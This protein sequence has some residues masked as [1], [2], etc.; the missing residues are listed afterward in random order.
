MAN[1]ATFAGY[2][3]ST[4][5]NW[6]GVY[7]ADGYSICLDSTSNPSYVTPAITGSTVP[8]AN[9]S[10]DVRALTKAS[11]PSQRINSSWYGSSVI[12]D[13]NIS[14]GT[15]RVGVYFFDGDNS[16]RTEQVQVLDG[17]TSAVLDTRALT[18]IYAFPIYQFWDCTG[19]V[20]IQVTITSGPNCVA[21]AIFFQSTSTPI[22]PPPAPT[23]PNF[24]TPISNAGRVAFHQLVRPPTTT[25]FPPSHYTPVPVASVLKSAT[26][27]VAYSETISAQGG[28]S[29]YTFAVTSGSLPAGLSLAGSTGIISGTATTVGS[30]S[31]TI[32]VTD[33]LSQTGSTAFVIGVIAPSPPG[34]Y[35]YVK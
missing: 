10:S 29:P 17:A 9:P 8:F 23:A 30:S 27:G 26:V 15:R 19:H 12:F 25:A 24:T 13:L 5:G 28:S 31:F 16:G 32:T 6:I 4:Q 33:S 3:T 35:G 34:N 20:K 1:T 11:N 21:S 2:D 7:G 18:N 14:S 22:V